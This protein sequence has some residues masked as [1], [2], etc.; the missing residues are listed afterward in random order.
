M[1]YGTLLVLCLLTG[2]ATPVAAE[3]E[4]ICTGVAAD[5]A[6]CAK[7]ERNFHSVIVAVH[8]W[9]GSC[10]ETFGSGKLSLF[11]GLRQPVRAFYDV[12]C[13]PYESRDYTIEQS[14]RHLR[15]HLLELK[16]LGYNE[17]F[18]L[19]HSMGGMVTLR[20]LTDL[21]PRCG[22]VQ[23]RYGLVGEPG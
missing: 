4:K 6:S 2:L 20:L 10:K 8:G 13:F 1:R 22:P 9:G 11:E 19:T 7:A 16:K 15:A 18:L 14:A 21:F 12:D 23:K 17:V 5:F 3:P